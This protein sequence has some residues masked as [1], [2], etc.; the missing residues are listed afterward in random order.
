MPLQVH[1]QRGRER[2]AAGLT[3]IAINTSLLK[4]GM[5]KADVG[6]Y[7]ASLLSKQQDAYQRLSQHLPGM[8]Q[9]VGV[10]STP[11]AVHLPV[12]PFAMDPGPAAATT[13]AA[14]SPAAASWIMPVDPFAMGPE[15]VA[16]TTPAT[17]PAAASDLRQDP[18]AIGSWATAATTFSAAAS[19]LSVDLLHQGSFSAIAESCDDIDEPEQAAVA[20]DTC[21]AAAPDSSRKNK[22]STQAKP[23]P[24]C[25]S[26]PAVARHLRRN[27]SDHQTS[28]RT[29][30]A[31]MQASR[32]ATAAAVRME[33]EAM[34]QAAAAANAEE[35]A[36]KRATAAAA[37][38]DWQARRQARAT[39]KAAADSWRI[40]GPPR[41]RKASGISQYGA[42]CVWNGLRQWVEQEDIDLVLKVETAAT[43]VETCW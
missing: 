21:S 38:A 7:I 13:P 39:A 41:R 15:P 22:S 14:T 37:R 42:A 34:R 11:G 3:P 12:D 8:L 36:A 30:K 43:A 23:R 18:F 29:P 19:L 27:T 5:T 20:S 26:S 2:L 16:A 31:K 28:G 32:M 40:T 17:S 1:Y 33:K 4:W 35:L 10:T 24:A 25:N 9:A 6:H